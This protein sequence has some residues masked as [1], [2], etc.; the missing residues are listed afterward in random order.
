M[1][2][3]HMPQIKDEAQWLKFNQEKFPGFECKEE[4]AKINDLVPSQDEILAQKTAAMAC[5]LHEGK[6]VPPAVICS[7][8]YIYDGHHRWS[9]MKM[10]VADLG[11]HVTEMKVRKCNQPC[12][13]MIEVC[14]QLVEPGKPNN[15]KHPGYEFAGMIELRARYGPRA[16]ATVELARDAFIRDTNARLDAA[17]M[18]MRGGD[19]ALVEIWQT[20]HE[21]RLWN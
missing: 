14:Q 18:E 12:P 19:A 9:A 2:R 17:G 7:D 20:V 13:T 11:A 8:Y 6:T 16:H 10:W 1:P 4:M 21:P 3:N 5:N 15:S